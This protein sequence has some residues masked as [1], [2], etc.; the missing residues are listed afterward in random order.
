MTI[1]RDI[2][3]DD[4]YTVCPEHGTEIMIFSD[5]PQCMDEEANHEAE[6]DGLWWELIGQYQD[7]EPESRISPP[8]WIAKGRYIGDAEGKKI[9]IFKDNDGRGAATAEFVA[10]QINKF[11]GFEV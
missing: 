3:G 7:Y 11:F 5:C 2:M 8:P 9:A 10:R 1:R 6:Q 4:F